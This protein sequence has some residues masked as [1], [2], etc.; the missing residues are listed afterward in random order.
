MKNATDFIKLLNVK[1]CKTQSNIVFYREK[2]NLPVLEKSRSVARNMMP[3]LSGTREVNLE[4]VGEGDRWSGGGL[5]PIWY[6]A[7]CRDDK[8]AESFFVSFCDFSWPTNFT[9]LVLFFCR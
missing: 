8:S 2:Y 1:L 4:L 5:A 6:I 3:V 9:M 7:T